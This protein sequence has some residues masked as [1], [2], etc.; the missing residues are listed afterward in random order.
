MWTILQDN[1]LE[2]FK[3]VKGIK[4]KKGKGDSLDLKNKEK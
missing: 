2:F 4:H 3:T 1:L